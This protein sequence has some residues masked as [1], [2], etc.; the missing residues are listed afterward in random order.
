MNS[1][2]ATPTKPTQTTS[3]APASPLLAL[4]RSKAWRWVLLGYRV[5]IGGV[6]VYAGWLKM[7]DPIAFGD[8]IATYQLLPAPLIGL[9]ALTLP[10]LEILLG[11]WL[12]SGIQPRYPAFGTLL[13]SVVFALAISQGI[14]RGIPIDCGC[15]GGGSATS[16]WVTLGRDLLIVLASAYLYLHSRPLAH[17]VAPSTAGRETAQTG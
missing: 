2:T 12:L 4:T 8:S 11:A 17:E 1:A 5:A 3:P 10:P 7:L 6:F 15:F 13:L 14:I 9:T 16:P